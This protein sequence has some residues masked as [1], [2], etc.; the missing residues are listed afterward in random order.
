MSIEI[1]WHDIDPRTGGRRYLCC[2]KFAG[3][4]L[5]K[6]KLVRRGAW[7]KGLEPT[8]AMWDHVLDSLQRRYVRREGVSEED[9][10]QVGQIIK[11]LPVERDLTE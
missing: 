1:K 3:K 6:S 4:W 7:D 5:F 10:A 11:N 2:E 8:R 9:L